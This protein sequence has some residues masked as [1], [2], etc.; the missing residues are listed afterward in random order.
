MGVAGPPG[1]L[2]DQGGDGAVDDEIGAGDQVGDLGVVGAADHRALAVMEEPEQG[3]V[4]VAEIGPGRR[5]PAHGIALGRLD[6]DHIGAGVAEQLGRVR[7]RDL[8]G[9][10]EYSDVGQTAHRPPF[11]VG[12]QQSYEPASTMSS[13]PSA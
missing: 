1:R 9:E 12:I 5:P 7:P 10:I 13:S 8:C 3:A 4:V 11:P 2:V 6:L